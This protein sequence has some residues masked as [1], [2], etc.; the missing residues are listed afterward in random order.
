MKMK[1]FMIAIIMLFSLAG[2]GGNNDFTLPTPTNELTQEQFSYLEDLGLT[3]KSYEEEPS[4]T[5]E[6]AREWL[7]DDV[8]WGR[9]FKYL[10]VFDGVDAAEYIDKTLDS[11]RFVVEGHSSA[12][13]GDTGQ[14]LAIILTSDKKIVGGYAIPKMKSEANQ[15]ELDGG[16]Y[17][18]NGE[19]EDFEEKAGMSFS[20]FDQYWAE[21]YTDK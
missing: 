17:P 8:A 15:E 12:Q 3:V 11:Y 5:F 4:Y 21:R 7:I 10:E 2:C 19:I 13:W 6:L 20:E 9:V 14:S 16:P 18:L 1:L